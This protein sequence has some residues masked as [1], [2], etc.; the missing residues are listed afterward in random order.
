VVKYFGKPTR[1]ATP[2]KE[3]RFTKARL[4]LNQKSEHNVPIFDLSIILLPGLCVSFSLQFRFRGCWFC[5]L[6]A[7]PDDYVWRPLWMGAWAWS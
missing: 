2:N 6:P 4:S 5:G 3:G 7:L 1:L